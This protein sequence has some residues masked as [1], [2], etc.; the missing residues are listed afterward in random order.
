MRLVG[1]DG[2]T[3]RVEHQPETA[4]IIIRLGPNRY[5]ASRDDAIAL[6]ALLVAAVDR[7]DSTQGP[8]Q[9]PF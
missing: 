7:L 3:P 1:R 9:C 4:C 2:I 6:A 5:I 8:V